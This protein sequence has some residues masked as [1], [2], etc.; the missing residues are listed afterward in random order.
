MYT[1]TLTTES[2]KTIYGINA[3]YSL[4][5]K[6]TDYSKNKSPRT[7][8]VSEYQPESQIITTFHN[9]TVDSESVIDF[10][11]INNIDITSLLLLTE[12]VEQDFPN[13]EIKLTTVFDPDD[14]IQNL[15][16]FI[17]FQKYTSDTFSR[18]YKFM[19]KNTVHKILQN[20]EI[21]LSY[22]F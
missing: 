12:Q 22:D 17:K 14:E 8:S 5:G 2:P 20:N 15:F 18:F 4:Y 16:I 10:L 21:Y 9:V 13:E 11:R 3:N 7:Y 6:E 19:G 1:P